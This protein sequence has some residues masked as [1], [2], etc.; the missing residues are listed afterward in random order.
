[1]CSGCDVLVGFATFAF[2]IRWPMRENLMTK[3]IILVD[4]FA[5]LQH[6]SSPNSFWW[7]NR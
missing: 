6:E 2:P 5:W 7:K 1:M 3:I 4:K